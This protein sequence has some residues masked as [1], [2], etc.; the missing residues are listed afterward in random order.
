MNFVDIVRGIGNVAVVMVVAGAVA[1]VGDR[2]GHQV[3]R[4]RLTL[5]GIRPR[6][7]STI[8]AIATGMVIALVVTLV[9]IFASQEVKTA[10]FRLNAINAQIA[11]LQARER[12]L[13]KKVNE[14]RLVWPVDTLMVPFY[15]IILQSAT[16]R[17]RLEE[18]RAFYFDAVKYVNANYTRLGLRPYKNPPDVDK[19]LQSFANDLDA[20]LSQANVM[21]TVTSDQ[22][23]FVGDQIHFGINV[24]EDK[25]GYEKGQVIAQLTIPGRSGANIN[26]ALFQLV[27][28]VTAY[29][30][31]L[32]LQNFLADNV[33]PLQLLPNPTQ[34]QQMIAKPGAYV[35][36]AFAA[37]DFYPHLGGIPIVIVLTQQPAQ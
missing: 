26:I 31:R 7:T 19:R 13:E 32:G 12:D 24:T 30:R 22:N 25:R 21:L 5:Y 4:R 33:Q 1:Y 10:F 16:P 9:A 2:V 8:V 37:E 17:Q 35:L 23:L 36:T 28:E 29:S 15:R 34:M 11:D 6:Y 20:V 18:T 27:N 14:G 3:G